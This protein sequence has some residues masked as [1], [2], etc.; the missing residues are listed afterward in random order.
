MSGKICPNCGFKNLEGAIFCRKCGFKL[1]KIG[2][3]PSTA[4]KGIIGEF[5]EWWG[6]QT[7]ENITLLT[8]TSVCCLGFLL[9]AVIG[10]LTP[11]VP[12]TEL[13]VTSPDDGATLAGVENI[14]IK[15]RTEPNATVTINGK[16][17]TTKP[18]GNF[19]QNVPIKIG[20]NTITIE[21]KAPKKESNSVTRT[22]TVLGFY[23]D[24]I[25]SFQY[26][27]DYRLT[28]NKSSTN[29][30]Y[31]CTYPKRN[32]TSYDIFFELEKGEGADR[33]FIYFERLELEGPIPLDE[34]V[35]EDAL[36]GYMIEAHGPFTL[37]ISDRSAKMVQ[38]DQF[39]GEHKY[40]FIY[41]PI[42]E[43]TIYFLDAYFPK[44]MCSQWESLETPEGRVEIPK[45]VYIIIKTIEVHVPYH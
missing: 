10:M 42:N 15:G 22:V 35:V 26:P 7:D 39:D 8:F 25:I 28:V 23:K 5:R 37:N 32:Y 30:Q 3:E 45:E 11:D 18:D 29:T 6:K 38:Y 34:F 20:E 27:P 2:S 44:D 14:T 36:E 33:S 4:K 43:T 1:S 40:W 12:T 31:S 21:A 13:V 16:N 17:V 24:E 41:I 19:T 9:I